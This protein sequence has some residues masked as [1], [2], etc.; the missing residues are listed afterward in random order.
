MP[1]K[2]LASMMLDHIACTNEEFMALIGRQP[3]AYADRLFMAFMATVTMDTPEGDDSEICNEITK[4]S[5]FIDVVDKHEVTILNTAGVGQELAEAHEYRDCM[6]EVQKWLE[7]ILCGIMEGIDV[8]VQTHNSRRLLYQHVV[9]S[10]E[11]EI[12]F[13]QIAT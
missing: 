9:H 13:G 10:Q 12:Y 11:D 5:E 3:R 7:D 6:E 8:L 2:T 4:I 1:M